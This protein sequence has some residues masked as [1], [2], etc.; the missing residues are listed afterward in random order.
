V[1]DSFVKENPNTFAAL[2][3]A[4]AAAAAHANDPRNRREVAR[5]IASPP[6]LDQPVAVVEQV[7][8]GRYADGL[9]NVQSA[10]GRAGFDPFPWHSMAVWI[11]TQLKR[12]GYV[13]GDLDYRA[14]AE[15]VFLANEARTRLG[16]LGLAVPERTYAQHRVMGRTF[17]PARPN[18]YLHTFAIRRS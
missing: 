15:Q 1:P 3:R 17:D 14:V 18:E 8:T 5:S 13:K 11:L 6:Y 12:W 16:L 4:L 10:P 7:L 2:F 9:G